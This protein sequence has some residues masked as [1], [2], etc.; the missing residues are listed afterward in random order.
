M[1]PAT[2]HP[3]LVH[4]P[5][6]LLFTAFLLD[7]IAIWR[8]DRFF[9]RAALVLL[10]LTLIAVALA[11]V[12][13]LYAA[14]KVLV[15]PTVRPILEA[16]R[17]D[18]LITGGLI[19]VIV[20]FRMR[21]HR[22]WRRDT[23]ATAQ[24]TRLQDALKPWYSS[25]GAYV[26]GLIMISATGVVGGSMVYDHGLGVAVMPAPGAVESAKPNKSPT[27]S[28]AN[29]SVAAGKSL[30]AS[31]CAR[32]HGPTPP[33]SSALVSSMGAAAMEQ[34]IAT[35]MPPGNPVGATSAK[36][37]VQYFNSIP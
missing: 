37:L 31:T 35:R 14:G 16:H 26:L 2:V 23:P 17:R 22:L 36:A 20:V 15:T 1:I 4:F 13:G 25:L 32:C 33:F 24:T 34:F 6:A 21:T 10:W 27:P 5:I 3:I 8:R 19:V 28:A 7:L 29:P 18:G 11:I 9:E 30:Y 12:A